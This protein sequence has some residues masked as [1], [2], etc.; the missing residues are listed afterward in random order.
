MVILFLLRDVIPTTTPPGF[1]IF[2]SI[3]MLFNPPSVL[4]MDKH[5]RTQLQKSLNAVYPEE[6]CAL[7]I[8]HRLNVKQWCVD[9][10]WPCCNVWKANGSE[11]FTMFEHSIE[12]ADVADRH[13]RFAIDPREQLA[14]QR[15]ARHQQMSIFGVAHSHPKGEATPSRHDLDWGLVDSLLL[16]QSKEGHQRAWWL[17]RHRNIIDILIDQDISSFQ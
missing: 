15:W 4:I 9:C 12:S 6:G 17:D 11:I 8:G 10:I 7:I 1:Q 3:D 13:T 2:R 14:A 16:I 5:R